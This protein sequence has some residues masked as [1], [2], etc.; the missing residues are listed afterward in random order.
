MKCEKCGEE[1]ILD[2]ELFRIANGCNSG[3]LGKRHECKKC[4]YVVVLDAK[5][6]I[7]LTV[8]QPTKK[9]D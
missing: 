3:M 5:D 1:M 7:L 2:E 9:L 6:N 4:G 8:T